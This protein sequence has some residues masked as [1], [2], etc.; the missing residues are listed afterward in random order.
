[1]PDQ[2]RKHLRF[3]DRASEQAQILQIEGAQI[4]FDDRTANR[5]RHGVTPSRTKR[6]EKLR[7][8]WSPDQIDHDIDAVSPQYFNNA[9]V[10][11][12]RAPGAETENV[13]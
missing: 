4:Q 2:I 11:C 9:V 12:K 3:Q 13:F 8:L 5:T 10:S 1:V 6:V 7:P